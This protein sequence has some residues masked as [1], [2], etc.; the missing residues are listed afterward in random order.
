M[1]VKQSAYDLSNFIPYTGG[2]SSGPHI[3]IIKS[4]SARMSKS[5][6]DKYHIH[7][8]FYVDLYFDKANE[9]IAFH[10]RKTKEAIS[11]KLIHDPRGGASIA[12]RRFFRWTGFKLSE[13]IGAYEPAAIEIPGVGQGLVIKLR[14]ENQLISP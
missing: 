11:P 5:L 13:V 8:Y 1:K 12:I 2:N 7:N 14:R 4:G 6:C 10:F 9:A 3:S